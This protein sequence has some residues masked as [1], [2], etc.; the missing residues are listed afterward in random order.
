MKDN[1]VTIA[2]YRDF[3]LA[4]LVKSRL[5][6]EGI[7]CF[8]ENEHLVSINWLYSNA[9]GGIK[10]KVHEKNAEKAKLIL[11]EE[12]QNETYER[13]EFNQKCPKCDSPEITQ[14]NK[15]RKAGALSLLFG[16]PLLLFGKKNVCK[17]CSYKWK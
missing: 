13:E 10:V 9:V 3:P 4:G 6:S 12:I 7:Q 14:Q 15:A 5:E 1:F 16:V 17:K 2:Q 8:L 11:K